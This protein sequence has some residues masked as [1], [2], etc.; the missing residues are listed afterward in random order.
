MKRL[1]VTTCYLCG[2]PLTGDKSLENDDHIPPKQLLVKEMRRKYRPRLITLRTHRTCNSSYSLDEEYFKHCLIPFGK[3]SEGGDAAWVKAVREYQSGENVKIV[4]HVLRQAKTTVYDVSLPP[5][6]IWLDY[7]RSRIDRI[8]GKIIKGLHFLDT[9][10]YLDLPDDLGTI[11]T[12]PNQ[13]PPDDFNELMQLL[14]VESRGEHQAVFAYRSFVSEE[15]HYWA[16]LIWDRIII[17]SCFKIG[18]SGV[19][20]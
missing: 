11:I 4:Q 7:D 9:Q 14:P 5:G 16:M 17:T 2:K 18:S 12:F 20:L 13:P 15:L 19:T 8:I 10:E 1:S 3:G 6:K